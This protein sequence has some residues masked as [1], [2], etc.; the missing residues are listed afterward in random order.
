MDKRR[1]SYILALLG[2]LI[3]GVLLFFAR[4]TMRRSG[5][6]TLPN[7]DQV[8]TSGQQQT[9][10]EHLELVEVR[11]DTVRQIVASMERPEAYTVAVEVETL[12]SGGSG[13][14]DLTAY[15]RGGITRI[16]APQLDGSIRHTL[17]DGEN[18]YVW[19]DGETT[20]LTYP[21]GDMTADRELRI[22]TY[23]DLAALEGESITAAD[24]REL[25]DLYCIYAE[26]EEDD[27]Y[28]ICYWIDVDSGLLVAAQRLCRGEPVYQMTVQALDTDTLPDAALFILPDG[29][30]LLP[31][32]TAAERAAK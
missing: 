22:P 12:W 1:A 27:L 5:G 23:E 17:L 7:L 13:T 26:A 24:Y 32:E 4:G 3:L 6:I 29:T 8:Q 16:D 9:E 10:E 20:F 30:E 2:V 19:Y 11:P 15:V 21:A 28:T 14:S 25:K 31:P 18:T